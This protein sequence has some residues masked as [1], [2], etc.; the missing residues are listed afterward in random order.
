[1]ASISKSWARE[2]VFRMNCVDESD[3]IFKI[4]LGQVFQMF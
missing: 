4:A 2:K 1:M 3:G